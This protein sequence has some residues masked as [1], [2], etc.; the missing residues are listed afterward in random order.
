MTPWKRKTNF[1][2]TFLQIHFSGKDSDSIFGMAGR[3]P[4]CDTYRPTDSGRAP[5]SQATSLSKQVP[6]ALGQPSCGLLSKKPTI[7]VIF[8]LGL[9]S[10]RCHTEQSSVA[11]LRSCL[12]ELEPLFFHAC[13]TCYRP[14]VPPG[15][16]SKVLCTI[17]EGLISLHHTMTANE[18]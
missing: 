18:L 6:A 5:H 2:G 10:L 7:L 1:L 13:S 11:F 9:R 15:F 16:R 4:S 12:G 14:T 8:G 3:V 17:E